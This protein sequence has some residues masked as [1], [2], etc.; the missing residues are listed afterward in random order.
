MVPSEWDSSTLKVGRLLDDSGEVIVNAWRDG[1]QAISKLQVFAENCLVACCKLAC[2][3]E[4][5][6]LF[7]FFHSLIV[8]TLFRPSTFNPV[9]TTKTL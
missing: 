6:D 7:Y 5:T 3:I 1:F 4:L 8:F 2:L 9:M